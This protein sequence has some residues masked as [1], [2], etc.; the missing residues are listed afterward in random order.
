MISSAETLL[1]GQNANLPSTNDPEP[2]TDTDS[3]A[4]DINTLSKPALAL[5]QP[6]V[7][8]PLV[9]AYYPDWVSATISPENI[10]M[11]CFGWAGFA[12][13]I[14]DQKF[15]LAFD[16]L[17]SPDILKRLVSAVRAKSTKAKISVGSWTS[18][19]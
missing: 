16:D 8:G 7:A 11:T 3:T 1:A 17:S 6:T 14:A 18:N 5:L 9:S 12:F 2:P 19:R 15:T 4:I 10:D 13:V